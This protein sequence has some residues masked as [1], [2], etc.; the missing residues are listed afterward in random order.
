MRTSWASGGATSMVSTLSGAPASQATAA[1]HEI[2]FCGGGK[3]AWAVFG[4]E[5]WWS[6]CP[7]VDMVCVRV[8]ECVCEEGGRTVEEMW[9]C[10]VPFC[11]PT[12]H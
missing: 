3:L 9:T 8:G 2:V 11:L 5:W 10:G 1:L 12:R 7:F 6:T 4:G